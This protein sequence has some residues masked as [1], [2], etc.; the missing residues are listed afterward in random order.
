MVCEFE[1]NYSIDDLRFLCLNLVDCV[2]NNGGS[3]W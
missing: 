2:I 1:D 3:I